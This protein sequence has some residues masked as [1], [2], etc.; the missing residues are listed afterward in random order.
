MAVWPTP[1]NPFRWKGAATSSQSLYS[2]DVNLA[3]KQTDWRELRG[4][5]P[6]FLEPLRQSPDTR[7]F[8]DFMRYG[9]A[10]VEERPDG[11]TIVLHD[12]RFDLRMRIEMDKDLAVRSAY[13]SWY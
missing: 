13:A 9:D 12:L 3:T 5:D 6:K 2:T 8:L 1:V 4:L 11:Y 7:V 10:S